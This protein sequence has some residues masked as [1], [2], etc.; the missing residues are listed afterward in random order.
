M[1]SGLH[2][3]P[4][5]KCECTEIAF[6]ETAAVA[7]EGEFDLTIGRDAAG[8]VIG[9]M[10]CP[11]IRQCVNIIHLFDGQRF[12]RR[13]LHHEHLSVIRLIEPF[14]GERVGVLVLDA[15]AFRICFFIIAD[16]FKIR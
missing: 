10:P 1:T 15:E 12:G 14:R 9:R 16:L 7:G 3:P 6:A 13:I 4:L 11:H 5:M 2:D 8:R